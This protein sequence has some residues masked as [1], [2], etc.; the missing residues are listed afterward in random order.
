[1]T[2]THCYFQLIEG[3]LAC[4]VFE[5][6]KEDTLDMRG[7]IDIKYSNEYVQAIA[8]AIWFREEKDVEIVKRLIFDLTV[9]SFSVSYINWQPEEMKPYKL[10]EGLEIEFGCDRDYCHATKEDCFDPLDC[11]RFAFLKQPKEQTPEQRQLEIDAT[12]IT[13]NACGEIITDEVAQENLWKEANR[14]Y[15]LKEHS[16]DGRDLQKSKFII[17]E[18]P[19]L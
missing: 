19:I 7:P 17:Y 5:M 3:R 2:P 15:S 14:L 11:S 16:Q 10:P 1:M 8:N 6:P 13:C 18:R 12:L 9:G 4:K